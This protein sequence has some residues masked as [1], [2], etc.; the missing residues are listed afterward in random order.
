ME[1]KDYEEDDENNKLDEDKT[2]NKLRNIQILIRKE[3][4]LK[5]LCKY[6]YNNNHGKK[7]SYKNNKR[8]KGSNK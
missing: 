1:E 5:G 3:S 8:N 4:S 2:F 7:I 6:K